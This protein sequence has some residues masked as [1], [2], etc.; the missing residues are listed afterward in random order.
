MKY[1]YNGKV[2][3]VVDGDTVDLEIDLGFDITVRDR[4]RLYGIDTPEKNSPVQYER[5]RAIAAS[6]RLADLCLGKRV[7]VQTFKRDKYGRYLAKIFIDSVCI[8]DAMIAEG[9]AVAYF[10]GAK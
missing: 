5:Q 8:N 7:E 9:Y 2:N 6:L 3:N 4:F 1:F 10:G